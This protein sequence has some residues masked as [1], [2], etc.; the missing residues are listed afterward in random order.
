M[1]LPTLHPL[2]YQTLEV[3]CPSVG[4]APVAAYLRAP[5]RCQIVEIASCLQGPITTANAT[6]VASVNGG[7][8]FASLTIPFAGSAGGQVNTAVP[9]AATFANED[10]A[11]SITPSGAGG[12]SVGCLFQVSVVMV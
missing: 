5:F 2:D 8:A 4:A 9:T 1:T 12:A 7:P 10:D 6:C 3:Y 11:I